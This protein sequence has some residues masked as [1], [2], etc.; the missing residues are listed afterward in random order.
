[1]DDILDFT[2]TAEQLGKPQGQDLASGNLTAP[3]IYAL[4]QSPE[5]E[6]IIQSEFAWCV[7]WCD[8]RHGVTCD[9]RS[10]STPLADACAL[11]RPCACSSPHLSSPQT[12]EF[13][14][15]GSL[16]RA[17]QLVHDAGGIAAARNLAEEQAQ[18]ARGALRGLPDSPSK[19]SL[20]LMVD[21][22]LQRI[23]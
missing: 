19:R 11:A 21:Y 9:A 14:E 6:E 10:P 7:T 12:G 16:A 23:H 17:L 13:T 18:L 20:E 2:Q 5:L 8:A 15:E 1:V 4:Q 3:V 22:V